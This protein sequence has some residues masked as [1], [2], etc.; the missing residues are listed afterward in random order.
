M[1]LLWKGSF[2]RLLN[3]RSV[4]SSKPIAFV[5]ISTSSL[6]TRMRSSALGMM[7]GSISLGQWPSRPH[8]HR[9]VGAVAAAG[10]RQRAEQLGAHARDAL[11]LA[12]SCSHL[13]AKRAAARIGPT[14]C[15]DEGPMP[16]LKRSKT[17]TAI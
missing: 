3:T 15:E 2:W 11:E 10:Q 1:P 4:F 8:Q 9:L 6:P 14:V 5:P 16:I 12:A 13:P 7:S 17:L